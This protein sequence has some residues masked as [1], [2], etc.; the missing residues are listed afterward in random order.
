VLIAIA[1]PSFKLLYLMDSHLYGSTG[2]NIICSF[3]L[4][5]VLLEKG[6]T[7]MVGCKPVPVKDLISNNTSLVPFG[8]RGSTLGIRYNR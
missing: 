2:D 5:S 4:I 7:S 6:K 1:F 8:V 3:T